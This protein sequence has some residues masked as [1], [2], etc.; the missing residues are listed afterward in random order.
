MMI[1]TTTLVSNTGVRPKQWRV[2]LLQVHALLVSGGLNAA[3][4]GVMM[5]SQSASAMLQHQLAPLAARQAAA[6]LNKVPQRCPCAAMPSLI[7]ALVA[8]AA[9][10][11]VSLPIDARRS[12]AV[13]GPSSALSHIGLQSRSGYHTF[14]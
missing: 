6:M 8:D 5:R 13:V 7:K 11:C 9:R 3:L 1:F 12:G 2:M 10:A 4:P 14:T